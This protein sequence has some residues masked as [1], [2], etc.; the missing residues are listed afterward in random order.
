LVSDVETQ[1]YEKIRLPI[2]PKVNNTT[3]IEAKDREAN[4][5]SRNLRMVLKKMY[6]HLNEVQKNTNKWLTTIR[7][8]I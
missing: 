8:T 2:T 6:K 4:E 1:K 3:V 5:S 7:K